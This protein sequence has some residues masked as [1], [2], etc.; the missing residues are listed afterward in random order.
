MSGH[1]SLQCYKERG[2]GGAEQKLEL[3][4]YFTEHE[5]LEIYFI[6]HEK[7]EIYFI[8]HE[9]LEICFIEHEK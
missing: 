9:K 3:R 7:L 2:G 8:E 5:R 4:I 6:E 1:G